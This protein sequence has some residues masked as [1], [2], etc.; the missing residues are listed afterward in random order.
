VPPSDHGSLV[1]ALD[2]LI[3]DASKRRAMRERGRQLFAENFSL[4]RVIGETLGVYR[5]A[6]NE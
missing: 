3:V 2:D 1:K 6:I 5:E 4:D